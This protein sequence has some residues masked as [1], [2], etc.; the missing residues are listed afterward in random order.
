MFLCLLI[1]IGAVAFYIGYRLGGYTISKPTQ[2][3]AYMTEKGD[4]DKEYENF[5]NYDGSAQS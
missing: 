5:L 2:R 4:T 3:K 1:L